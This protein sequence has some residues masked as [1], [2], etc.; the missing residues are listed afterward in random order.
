M[1]DN[2]KAKVRTRHGDSDWFRIEKGV[3]QGCIISPHIFNIYSECIMREVLEI[4]G[5]VKVSG[6]C[7]TKL[8]Y[9]DDIV[10]IAD[11]LEDLQD[12]VDRANRSSKRVGLSS[13]AK[14]QKC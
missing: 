2:Q 9:A 4:T 14:K 3:R 7:I 13:N 6:R 5:N 10:L 12:L 11:T 8:R 1:Y